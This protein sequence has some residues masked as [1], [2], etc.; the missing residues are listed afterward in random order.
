M[1]HIATIRS[2]TLVTIGFACLLLM[3]TALVVSWASSMSQGK[4]IIHQKTALQV[5]QNTLLTSHYIVSQRNQLLKLIAEN[6][7]FSQQHSAYRQFKSLDYLFD[8][9]NHS[10]SLQPDQTQNAFQYFNQ[11][12]SRHSG[13]IS[14]ILAQDINNYRNQIKI[15]TDN[16]DNQ[17]GSNP[18]M[19]TFRQFLNSAAIPQQ[20]MAVILDDNL[21]NDSLINSNALIRQHLD[22]LENVST[23]ANFVL[24]LL[25]GGGIFS[26][27]FTFLAIRR[28]R[29]TEDTLLE[30]G[31]RIRA[32]Y[33]ISTRTGLTQDEQIDA[34]LEMGRRLFGMEVGMVG[35]P[36][37]D[38]NESLLLNTA[39]ATDSPLKR[40]SVLP[41]DKTFCYVT[42]SSDTP[43]AIHHVDIS[44]YRHHPAASNAG[45]QTYIGTALHVNGEKFATVSFSHRKQRKTPFTDADK[46]FLTLIANRISLCLENL[47]LEADLKQVKIEPGIS[48]KTSHPILKQYVHPASDILSKAS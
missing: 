17:L 8:E 13:A 31:K 25:T 19:E 4:L 29:K 11:H 24:I 23:D 35:R 15:I 1:F 7:N 43:V 16:I 9:L 3:L 12:S 5:Y 48:T 47:L 30:Q 37:T 28:T 21:S 2:N 46:E 41:L 44:K 20:Q 10:Q 38:N 32:L 45:I 40:G 6:N 36:D 39:A 22:K 34:I 14:E 33:D 18:G 42:F 27:T 26:T